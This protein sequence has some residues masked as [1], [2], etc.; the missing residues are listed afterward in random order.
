[1]DLLPRLRLNIRKKLSLGAAKLSFRASIQVTAESTV[2][3]ESNDVLHGLRLDS[4]CRFQGYGLL[5]FEALS[6]LR[7]T[8]PAPLDGL[9]VHQP[10]QCMTIT[11]SHAMLILPW[12][13]GVMGVTYPKWTLRLDLRPADS[14]CL[15]SQ[16]RCIAKNPRSRKKKK[17]QH[18]P[19]Q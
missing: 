18:A 14:V 9:S 10:V 16:R 5:C 3:L 11:Q 12:Q 2:L 4:P 6:L 1:M 7:T 19:K 15:P 8:M 17:E 13:P